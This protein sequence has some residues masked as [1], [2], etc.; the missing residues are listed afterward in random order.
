MG[1]IIPRWLKDTDIVAQIHPLLP[2][3]LIATGLFGV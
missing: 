3:S 1:R 2:N